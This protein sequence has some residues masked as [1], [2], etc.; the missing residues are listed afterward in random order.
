[1]GGHCQPPKMN[2]CHSFF[3]GDEPEGFPLVVAHLLLAAPLGEGLQGGTDAV[4]DIV[5]RAT[6]FYGHTSDVI[7]TSTC[8]ALRQKHGHCSC[9]SE[10]NVPLH[11]RKND[12]KFR[13]YKTL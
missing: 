5:L 7:L 2:C 9:I 6:G 11:P 8:K 12:G 4:D 10:K 1:M 3:S 13:R